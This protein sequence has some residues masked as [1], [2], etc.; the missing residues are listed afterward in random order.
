M[1]LNIHDSGAHNS[2]DFYCSD[3]T[4]C[5]ATLSLLAITRACTKYDHVSRN[6]QPT[7]AFPH[8]HSRHCPHHPMYTDISATPLPVGDPL[9]KP[10][11]FHISHPQM[12]PCT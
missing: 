3:S 1:I 5:H 12:V 4:F 11:F 7:I 2:P 6:I 10:P 8:F 9:Y